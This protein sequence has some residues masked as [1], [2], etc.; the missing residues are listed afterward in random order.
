MTRSNGHHKV[1]WSEEHPDKVGEPVALLVHQA[2]VGVHVN[3]QHH[4]F[5]LSMLIAHPQGRHPEWNIWK[6]WSW[7]LIAWRVGSAV[8]A[9]PQLQRVFCQMTI[10]SIDFGPFPSGQHFECSSAPGLD[11][12]QQALQRYSVR[13]SSSCGCCCGSDQNL[14]S[15]RIQTCRGFGRRSLPVRSHCI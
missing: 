6:L 3:L 4:S 13:P 14:F 1:L 5:P 10:A 2:G 7:T 9:I 15:A 12:P 11:L 8:K